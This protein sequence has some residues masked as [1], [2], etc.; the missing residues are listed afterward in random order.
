MIKRPQFFH[1]KPGDYV[2]INIPVIAKYEWHPFTISSAP[3]QSGMPHPFH[4]HSSFNTL[5]WSSDA[6]KV[7]WRLMM[8]FF[9]IYERFCTRLVYIIPIKQ[10]VL[11]QYKQLSLICF[12]C[13][14]WC[15][16]GFSF[17]PNKVFPLN[18]SDLNFWW[19]PFSFGLRCGLL[20]LLFE[21]AIASI[22]SWHHIPRFIVH[23]L[24]LFSDYPSWR[25][26]AKTTLLNVFCL[27][28]LTPLAEILDVT[29]KDGTVGDAV[30]KSSVGSNVPFLWLR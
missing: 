14:V 8:P 26:G 1:F 13:Q 15:A 17:W 19:R 16:S 10:E 29:V 9:L 7:I 28:Q 12:F 24:K 25:G 22:L 30:R 2:Y 27:F 18:I 11:C 5:K 21:G 20:F 4:I 3:E 6:S 23:Q